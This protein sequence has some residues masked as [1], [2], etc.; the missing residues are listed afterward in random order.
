M[1]GMKLAHHHHALPVGDRHQQRTPAD[2]AE[3][4]EGLRGL[5]LLVGR[6]VA[7]PQHEALLAHHRRQQ[8]V[9]YVV[10][11]HCTDE[12]ARLVADRDANQVVGGQPRRDL[13]DRESRRLSSPWSS[14]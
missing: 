5:V 3:L 2:L 11:R 8:P 9:E 1:L 13:A 6:K 7:R 12:P 10:H 14:Q 4:A